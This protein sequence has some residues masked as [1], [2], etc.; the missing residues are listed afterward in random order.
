MWWLAAVVSTPTIHCQ[1]TVL[2]T[3]FIYPF[4]ELN[5]GGTEAFVGG[6]EVAK[7]FNRQKA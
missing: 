6:F 5:Q 2:G 4:A 3:H 1:F 7:E